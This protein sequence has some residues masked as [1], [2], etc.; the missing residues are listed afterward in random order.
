MLF[1]SELD[2]AWRAGLRIMTIDDQD[3]PQNLKNI[4]D[5][6]IVLYVKGALKQEDA[7]GIAI[8]GSRQASFYGLSCAE[9]FATRLSERGFTIISGM[10]R[11]IDTRAHRG[12]LKSA[13][14]TVA[15]IGS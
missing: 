5:P 13:G 8:V 11:G 10:A 9:D 15:V 2:S 4:I 6:P 12:A 14:R 7:F 1:R 3:Y